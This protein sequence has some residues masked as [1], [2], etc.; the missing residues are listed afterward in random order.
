MRVILPETARAR[1]DPF[2]D[3]RYERWQDAKFDD[4]RWRRLL[5]TKGWDTQGFTDAQ[6]HS[7][8][9][10]MWYRLNA[11]IPPG[12]AGKSIWLYAPA[13]VNEAWVWV[14]GQYAG[15]RPHIMPWER[16]QRV[17]LDISP[18]VQPGHANQITFR[19]NNNIDVFGASGIY[20]RMF[21]YAR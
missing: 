15:H 19:I 14:N 18:L 5:T 13:V 8:R 3:G 6:G 7:Y 11:D 1:P 10:L 2:D 12:A 9:G 20:E 4:S 16:P 21:L 17:E